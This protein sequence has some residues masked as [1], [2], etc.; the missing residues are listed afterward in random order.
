[1][2]DEQASR[3]LSISGFGIIER[4]DWHT[5]PQALAPAP[6]GTSGD[7]GHPLISLGIRQTLDTMSMPRQFTLKESAEGTMP[8]LGPRQGFKPLATERQQSSPEGDAPFR[9]RFFLP[10]HRAGT[11]QAITS[12]PLSTAFARPVRCI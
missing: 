5:C 11:R 4:R 10:C 9:G 12:H 1:E 6:T 3:K 8:S 2:P 7:V